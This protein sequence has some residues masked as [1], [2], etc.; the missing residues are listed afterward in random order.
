M[1]LTDDK[2]NSLE[3]EQID[4]AENKLDAVLKDCRILGA[5]PINYPVTDGIIIYM[6]S[7][8]G[9]RLALEIGN[10]TDFYISL[11]EIR[12]DDRKGDTDK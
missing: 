4:A 9:D 11:A 1:Q 12:P 6:E 10:D 2:F 8:S 3:W 5:E 7:K